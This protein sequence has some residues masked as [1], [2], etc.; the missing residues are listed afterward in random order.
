ME[1]VRPLIARCDDLIVV[2]PV[3]FAGPPAPYKAL[4]DRMQ[5]FYERWD[6]DRRRGVHARKRPA[7]LIA[8]GEGGDPHGYDPL[9][10][11]TRSALA[12]AGFSLMPVAECISDKGDTPDLV[13]DRLMHDSLWA[14][15]FDT[16]C[17]NASLDSA[18]GSH[19]SSS[20]GGVSADDGALSEGTSYRG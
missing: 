19:A 8:V 9:V 7:R 11:C 15:L 20:N 1:R 10:V 2:S 5:P 17:V 4:L 13:C 12:V 16:N 3:Y 6:R 18:E 14:S